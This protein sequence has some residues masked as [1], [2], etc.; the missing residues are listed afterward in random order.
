MGDADLLLAWRNDPETRH[1]ELD[2]TPVAPGA[3]LRW[4]HGIPAAPVAHR[5]YIPFPRPIPVGT[6]RLDLN[7][8]TATLSLLI[9]PEYRRQG[10]GTHLVQLL[11]AEATQRGYRPRAFVK[12]TNP[13]SLQV[14]FRAGFELAPSG[15]FLELTR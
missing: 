7:A 15:V 12:A 2:E 3:H 14:F 13:G 9:A 4:L 10:L 5:L 8:G 1:Q 11:V 6:G